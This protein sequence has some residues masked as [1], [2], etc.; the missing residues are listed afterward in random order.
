M[1]GM[2]ALPHLV[3]LLPEAVI[4]VVYTAHDSAAA[5]VHARRL[6]A[7]AYVVKHATPVSEGWHRC[8]RA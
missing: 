2:D 6:G 7:D 4:I 3:E 5:R 1:S 8:A